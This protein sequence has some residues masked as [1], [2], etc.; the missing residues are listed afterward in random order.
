MGV[1]GVF[2]FSSFLIPLKIPL[3]FLDLFLYIDFL[4]GFQSAKSP[5]LYQRF[6]VF[7]CVAAVDGY[8]M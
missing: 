6:S 4:H 3:S 7:M 1:V 5:F 2:V 8:L